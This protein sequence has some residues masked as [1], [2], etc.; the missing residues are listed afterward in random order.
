MKNNH[1][2]RAVAQKLRTRFDLRNQGVDCVMTPLL[3]RMYNTVV[4]FYRFCL[5]VHFI[6]SRLRRGS[7]TGRTNLVRF[8]G[9]AATILAGAAVVAAGCATMQP[10]SPEET[11][12]ERAQA[13]AQAVVA[14]DLRRVYEFFTPVTRETLKFEDWSGSMNRGFW[15]AASVDKVECPKRDICEAS[16]TVEYEFRGGRRTTP[17]K[18]TWI[19]ENNN[20]WY[21]KKG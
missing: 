6:L 5:T 2:G 7:F 17:L 16:L 21:A 9:R 11:V 18:E 1:S 4:Y 8:S 20:W 12:K 3:L 10:K 13:R 14:G 19:Q 15:K